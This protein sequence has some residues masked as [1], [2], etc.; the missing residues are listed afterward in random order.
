MH[1]K[2]RTLAKCA[3]IIPRLAVASA[4]LGAWLIARRVQ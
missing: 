1:Y 2:H 3:E 4:A